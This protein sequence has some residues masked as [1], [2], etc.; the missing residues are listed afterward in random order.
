MCRT[1]RT[2]KVFALGFAFAAGCISG[3]L[4]IWTAYY[5]LTTE[6]VGAPANLPG[7]LGFCYESSF[8]VGVLRSL[9]V[10]L[11]N[12]VQLLLILITAY[13]LGYVLVASINPK[14]LEERAER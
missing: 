9:E 8:R 3:L 7:A 13:G 12:L 14:R 11:G 4:P 5:P 6:W 10:N 1:R 2:R